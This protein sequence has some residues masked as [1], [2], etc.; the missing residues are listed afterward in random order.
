MI[1]GQSGYSTQAI[2]FL[3][4]S[5]GHWEALVEKAGGQSWETLLSTPD[6]ARAAVQL[7]NLSA[8][9]GNLANA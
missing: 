1:F 6:H 3:R 7:G 4:E 9:M 2:L 8:T 5:I